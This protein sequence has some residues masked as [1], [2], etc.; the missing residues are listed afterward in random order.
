MERVS[1]HAARRTVCAA[2]DLT[3]WLH[4]PNYKAKIYKPA[5]ILL[6]VIGYVMFVW[7]KDIKEGGVNPKGSVHVGVI[8]DTTGFFATPLGETLLKPT[9]ATNPAKGN[10][11]LR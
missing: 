4:A 2:Q 5:G 1:H 6:N 7:D 8:N 3:N 10:R 9:E 11:N